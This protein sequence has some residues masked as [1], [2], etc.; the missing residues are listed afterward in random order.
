MQLV[1]FEVCLKCS[2]AACFCQRSYLKVF[3][4]FLAV[5]CRCFWN[6]YF[7]N[8]RQEKGVLFWPLCVCV[9]VYA[10]Q[11]LKGWSDL[12]AFLIWKQVTTTVMVL[13]KFSAVSRSLFGRW[14]FFISS[15]KF[16]QYPAISSIFITRNQRACM[17]VVW[18]WTRWIAKTITIDK[19]L[20]SCSKW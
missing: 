19:W 3:I 1:R 17:T 8:F 18:T 9:C 16:L 2:N 11:L 13:S 14:G 4:C 20:N 6:L 5:L 10:P 12:N 7:V 15:F